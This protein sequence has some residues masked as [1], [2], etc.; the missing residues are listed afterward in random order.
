MAEAVLVTCCGVLTLSVLVVCGLAALPQHDAAFVARGTDAPLADLLDPE[1]ADWDG[2]MAVSWGPPRYVTEFRALHASD[3]LALRFAATD[4]G[5]W[6]T[7]TERDDALWNEE[8]VEI[9]IDPDGD[10]HNY[11]E[12]EINPAGVVCDLQ[13]LTAT[14]A[15]ESD[16]GWDFS[17]L[18]TRVTMRRDAGARTT[19]WI[20]TAILPW[21]GF[22]SLG[23]TAVALPPSRDDRW[24][25]NVF[26]IKRPGGPEQP[27]RDVI[28]AP[29]SPTPSASFHAPESFRDLIFG[30]R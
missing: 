26:R 12:I 17:G 20:A 18:A 1:H 8:V 24:K 15:L 21:R 11:A 6:Y 4:D 2:A 19:G 16:I 10:G 7:L 5:P 29:W 23:D 28:L 30:G 14:P 27:E 9:F 25:F 22:A 3:G 13:I